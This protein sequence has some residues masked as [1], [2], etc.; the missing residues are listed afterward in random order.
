MFDAR[1]LLLRIMPLCEEEIVV[2]WSYLFYIKPKLKEK[3]AD[4][5]CKQYAHNGNYVHN[6]HTFA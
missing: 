2:D 1:E 6:A 3:T 5:W 4:R